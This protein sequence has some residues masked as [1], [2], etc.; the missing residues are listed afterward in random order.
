MFVLC[1]FQ[2]RTRKANRNDMNM[3]LQFKHL[4]SIGASASLE[5]ESE[6]LLGLEVATVFGL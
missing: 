2:K 4:Q 1:I 3:A 6:R 5:E